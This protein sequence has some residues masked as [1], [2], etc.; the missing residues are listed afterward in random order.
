[1]RSGLLWF[2]RDADKHLMQTIDDAAKRYREKFGVSPD[3]CYVNREQLK[4]FASAN[5]DALPRTLNLSV[6]P[7]ETIMKNHVWL[8][9]KQ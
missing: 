9:M 4:A 2:D 1:M 8:G 7:K 6:L 5:R 3:T